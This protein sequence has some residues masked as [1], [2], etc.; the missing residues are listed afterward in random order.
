[1]VSVDSAVLE[2]AVESNSKIHRKCSYLYFFFS[3]FS[4]TRYNLNTQKL[5]NL[6][7]SYVPIVLSVTPDHFLRH[8]NNF[9]ILNFYS[10]F[11]R[12]CC[13]RVG[14]QITQKLLKNLVAPKMYS[15]GNSF[16]LSGFCGF[17]CPRVGRHNPQ[18]VL[19]LAYLS[20]RSH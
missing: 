3:S 18:K 14:G 9:K 16:F 12:F 1:M 5:L 8:R 7:K 15:S 10:C 13:A 20:H 17:C 4:A 2:M 6:R 19:I 11:C